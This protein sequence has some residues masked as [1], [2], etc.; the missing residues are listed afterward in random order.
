[1]E[2][3][4]ESKITIVSLGKWMGITSGLLFLPI[5]IKVGIVLRPF[6]FLLLIG[7]FIGLVVAKK[8][9]LVSTFFSSTI[10]LLYIYLASYI[11]INALFLNP[12]SFIKEAIQQ[13]EF[14]IFLYLIYAVF[15]RKES[16]TAFLESFYVSIALMVSYTVIWHIANGH[17]V[18]YKVLHEPKYLF[19]FLSMILFTKSFFNKK[20]T[21]PFLMSLVFLLFSLERKG[22]V[23]FLFGM[24]VIS[25]YLFT[26]FKFRVRIIRIYFSLFLVS[27][28]LVSIVAAGA[29]AGADA[30]S[31]QFADTGTAFT[32]FSLEDRDVDKVGSQSNATRLYLLAFSLNSIRNKPLAG[33]GTDRFKEENEKIAK[34]MGEKKAHGSH[35]EYQ[36]IAV[37]N[38]IPALLVYFSIWFISYRKISRYVRVIKFTSAKE[39]TEYL[40]IVGSLVY[41]AVINFFLGGGATNK[42]FLALPVGMIMGYYFEKRKSRGALIHEKA[43]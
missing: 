8:K 23:S 36:R 21:I 32:E 3:R 17:I 11:A 29:F 14:M 10:S 5:E 41:G 38:G 6:D 4:K 15:S 31:D 35:N 26:Y 19:G 12:A 37:E 9:S 2:K 1:M 39:A 43:Q 25:Y 28:L 7:I 34:L 22:W 13:I 33:I 42:F 24:L 18:R 27:V 16:R 20:F 40:L 30:L